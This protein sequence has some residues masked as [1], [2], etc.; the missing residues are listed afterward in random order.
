[1]SEPEAKADDKG[2]KKGGNKL[3]L[4][5]GVVVLLLG[6]GGG[7]WWFAKSAAAEGEHAEGTGGEASGEEHADADSHDD[8]ADAEHDEDETAAKK[9]KRKKN[10]QPAAMVDLDPFVVNL[11]D[12]AGN[13]YVKARI[14]LGVDEAEAAAELGG[15]GG[16][17]AAG[18]HGGGGG[19]EDAGA[20]AGHALTKTRVRAVILEILASYTAEEITSRDGKT[21]LKEEIIEE[22]SALL[23]N[24]EVMEVLLTDLIVQ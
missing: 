20:A 17:A 7:Y 2:K 23:H 16:D 13:R 10:K 12:P 24:G 6:G 9:K 18:A 1:M 19:E 22:V 14:S 8:D 15:G 3:F 5:I 21:S 4:I 11:A